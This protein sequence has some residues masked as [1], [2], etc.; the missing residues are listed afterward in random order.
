MK[1]KLKLVKQQLT[2]LVLE[3]RAFVINPDFA[4]HRIF[5]PGC[6]FDAWET[7]TVCIDVESP[8][9]RRYIKVHDLSEIPALAKVLGVEP[10]TTAIPDT[11]KPPNHK[12]TKH[13]RKTVFTTI[14]RNFPGRK[15]WPKHLEQDPSIN[16]ITNMLE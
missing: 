14:G 16:F 8:N 11:P 12:P 13:S 10:A 15:P 7:G 5:T 1:K 3:K 2:K 9:N 6:T 4:H